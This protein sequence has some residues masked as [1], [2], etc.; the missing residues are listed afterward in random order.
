MTPRRPLPSSRAQELFAE[1]IE[2]APERRN[3][4]LAAACVGD[5][6]LQGEVAALLAADRAA[7]PFLDRPAAASE[8]VGERAGAW[9]LEELLSGGG[10]GDVY[11]AVRDD[12]AL[13]WR[14][15]V[16]VL[17][18]GHDGAALVDRFRAEQR[19]LAAL[20]HPNIVALV[21]AGTLADGR[22]FLAMELIDGLPIDRHCRE[23]A[24]DRPERVALLAQVCDALDHAHR[25]L[26]VHCDLKPANVLVVRE[27]DR[28]L[29]KL[30]DFGLAQLLGGDGVGRYGPLERDDDSVDGARAFTPRWAS[31]EQRRGEPLGVASDVFGVGLLL[32]ELLREGRGEVGK[33]RG[34]AARPDADLDAIVERAT[35]E[36]PAQRYATVAALAADLRAWQEGRPVAARE[37]GAVDRARK[38]VAR[39]RVAAAALL[40]AAL[41]LAW[42]GERAWRDWQ[43]ARTEA[44]L[45][46]R[47]HAAA[48]E[49]TSLL[50]GLLRDARKGGDATLRTALDRAAAE[51]DASPPEWPEVEGRMRAILGRLYLG[52]GL[53]EAAAPQ[54]ARALDLA[55]RT[56]GFGGR[57]VE[58]L[59]KL[60]EGE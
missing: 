44:R 40:V 6:A 29:V 7:P 2:L 51:L 47:A 33:V 30:L 54:L 15:A 34:R 53:R 32:R 49:V 58:E 57:E 19:T 14:V 39:H 25:R 50:E 3:E 12:T 22:P 45:G 1:L 43:S 60:V 5:A 56:R 13:P 20:T 42:S 46:W 27:G 48:V 37:G 24:F 4:A 21:D 8:L 18:H 35:R 28:D 26:V 11:R 36:E 38:L 52:L 17:R 10:M 59:R 9:R 55:T 23:Q 31:P 16:K 41:A